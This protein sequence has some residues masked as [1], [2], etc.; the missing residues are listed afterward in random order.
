MRCKIHAQH[1]E[2]DRG[3]QTC[4]FTQAEAEFHGGRATRPKQR[5]CFATDGSAERLDAKGGFAVATANGGHLAAPIAW[6]GFDEHSEPR[7]GHLEGGV[8]M[9]SAGNSPNG[10]RTVHGTSPT[11]ELDFGAK[12]ELRTRAPGARRGD[13]ERRDTR[14]ERGAG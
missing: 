4:V 5:F 9:D 8:T 10:A 11:A 14:G 12:G 2:L 6:M 3:A 13:E 7:H 1:A